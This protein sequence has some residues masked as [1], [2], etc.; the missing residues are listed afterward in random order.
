[1][2]HICVEKCSVF[3]S[4]RNFGL[5]TLELCSVFIS[6]SNF[7]LFT[8]ELCSASQFWLVCLV[9]DALGKS[10]HFHWISATTAHFRI[11]PYLT[12]SNP[13][14]PP[15]TCSHYRLCT[16]WACR[17]P[18]LQQHHSHS[19]LYNTFY[20]TFD[21]FFQYFLV[22]ITQ[23]IANRPSPVVNIVH[24]THGHAVTEPW[25]DAAA[26][27]RVEAIFLPFG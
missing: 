4:G 10:T 17:T 23:T 13:S 27:T 20:H 26:C 2:W 18:T 5:F 1:M 9:L 15:C 16:H 7:G 8:L 14:Q 3:I 19:P 24:T 6:G 12:H 21:C 25:V 11:F 22:L